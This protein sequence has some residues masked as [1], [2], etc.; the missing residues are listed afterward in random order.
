MKD[1]P[2]EE[3]VR[4][5]VKDL[6]RTRGVA[7]RGM[8]TDLNGTKKVPLKGLK[9]RLS[10]QVSCHLV[11]CDACVAADV[12][13]FLSTKLTFMKFVSYYLMYCA[14]FISN[15]FPCLFNVGISAL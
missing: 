5:V 14:S 15:Y 1:L 8:V 6:L 2:I 13:R 9:Y 7:H 4:G 12:L 11:V 3:H 10:I